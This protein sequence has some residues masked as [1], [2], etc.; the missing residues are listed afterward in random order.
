MAKTNDAYIGSGIYDSGMICIFN[1]ESKVLKEVDIY[2]DYFDALKDSGRKYK[3]GQSRLCFNAK[4]NRLILAPLFLNSI[5]IYSYQHNDL[6][7]VDSLTIGKNLLKKRILE[8]EGNVDI[9][10]TDIY[11]CVDVCCSKDFF[12]VLY[13]GAK[14]EK[15]NDNTLMYILK[16][17][18]DGTLSKKY[19]VNSRIRNICVSEDDTKMYAILLNEDLDYVIAKTE[20]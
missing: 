14:M 1:E 20:L 5:N 8:N 10:G 15:K 16:L 18:M 7:K 6:E 3:L 13:N 2:P 11:H 9:E 4:H 12:Y 19:N 17:A